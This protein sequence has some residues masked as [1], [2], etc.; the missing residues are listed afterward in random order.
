MNTQT[1]RLPARP[2]APGRVGT[3]SWRRAAPATPGPTKGALR[4]FLL[5]A[6]SRNTSPMRA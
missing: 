5:T 2:T 6:P 1:T 4:T 3:R